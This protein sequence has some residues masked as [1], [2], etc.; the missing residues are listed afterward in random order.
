MAALPHQ[1]MAWL[2][3]DLMIDALERELGDG[4]GDGIT[5]AERAG[6]MKKIKREC[7]SPS[8]PRKSSSRSRRATAST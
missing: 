4:A 2:A 3:P 8:A 7:F 5:S 6:R 1:F